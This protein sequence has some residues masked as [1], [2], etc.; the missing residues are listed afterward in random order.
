[1][2]EWS[3]SRW[4]TQIG[5]HLTIVTDLSAWTHW[6]DGAIAELIGHMRGGVIWVWGSWGHLRAGWETG[7]SAK[8]RRERRKKRERRDATYM[9]ANYNAEYRGVGRVFIQSVPIVE[10]TCRWWLL[11]DA[12][13]RNGD[14]IM[15]KMVKGERKNTET[16]I[17]FCKRPIW[18]ELHLISLAICS[19]G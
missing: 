7:K 3:E 5:W 2:G 13:W 18:T 4:K 17:H 16:K 15:L 9:V 1:M 10:V 6:C 11:K 14:D 19:P 12:Q 8:E